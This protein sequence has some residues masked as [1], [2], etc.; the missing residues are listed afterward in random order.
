MK[1]IATLA[2]FRQKFKPCTCL[3]CDQ[4]ET[5]RGGVEENAHTVFYLNP[6]THKNAASQ[7]KLFLQNYESGLFWCSLQ[8]TCYDVCHHQLATNYNKNCAFVATF[9]NEHYSDI[10]N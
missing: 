9:G 3:I 6:S 1:N 5:G 10:A 4:T 2:K 8:P 7:L